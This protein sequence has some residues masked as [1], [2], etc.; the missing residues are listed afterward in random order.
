MLEWALHPTDN[1]HPAY[2]WDNPSQW[3]HI[4][5][6]VNVSTLHN[7]VCVCVCVCVLTTHL[8]L[9]PHVTALPHPVCYRDSTICLLLSPSLLLPIWF[10]PT[11]TWSIRTHNPLY[12]C[13][14]ITCF[15]CGCSHASFF[16]FTSCLWSYLGYDVH[17]L[18]EHHWLF[19]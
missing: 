3:Q 11:L 5:Y 19:V 12:N 9:I 4:L 1:K 17:T 10:H 7:C 8:P 13:Y 14:Y 18:M 15:H 6:C 2:K 16:L